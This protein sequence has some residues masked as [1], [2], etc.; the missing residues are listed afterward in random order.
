M[1]G[2]EEISWLWLHFF[3]REKWGQWW[4]VVS[5]CYFWIKIVK[6]VIRRL[7]LPFWLYHWHE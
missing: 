7:T 3:S 4:P 1:E 2:K 5:N 6:V